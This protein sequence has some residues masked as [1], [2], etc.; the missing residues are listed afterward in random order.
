MAAAGSSIE[1]EERKGIVKFFD[2]KG[3]HLR[4][5]KIPNCDNVVD[6]SWEGSGLRLSIGAGSNIYC[7]S[8][9]PNYKWCYLGNGTVV[10][11]YQKSD[12][13]DFCL[14]FWE[15]KTD[16]KIFKYVKDLSEIKGEGEYCAVFSKVNDDATVQIDLCNSL[17]TTLE[18]KFVSLDVIGYHM[19]R[20]HIIIISESYVYLWQY[21]SQTSRLTMFEAS[22][23]VSLRKIGR[24]ICWFIDEKP[25]LNNIYDKE[26]FDNTREC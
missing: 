6:I 24:E 4:N 26:Q 3:N 19:S 18:T 11:A 15:T 21:R 25:D 22:S 9:K 23:Q 1:F 5:L 13:V 2:N 20:T 16:R 17:G 14:V 10:F 7:A 8:I 12:R